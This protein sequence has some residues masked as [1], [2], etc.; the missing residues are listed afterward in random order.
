[1]ST[2]LE[3][4]STL[5]G[6]A[7]ALAE[8]L[9]DASGGT[10]ISLGVTSAAVGDIVKVKAVDENGKPTA[11]EAMTAKLAN[12][13][14][15][16]F[17]GAV[18]GSYDGSTPL[19]VE[20]PSGGGGS[21][22]S[23]SWKLIRTINIV[24]GTSSYSFDTDNNGNAFNVKNFLIL[25]DAYP[26]RGGH[27]EIKPNGNFSFYQT[28]TGKQNLP[29]SFMMKRLTDERYILEN[30]T[31]DNSIFERK[32]SKV[33]SS[34]GEFTSFVFWFSTNPAS[35]TTMYILGEDV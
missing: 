26:S 11:W 31:T 1:M 25:I 32:L 2:T 19:S 30:S 20:I 22:A 5:I 29:F 12:P 16:T 8:T 3:E 33:Y 17:T 15:L 27:L 14:A 9:P 24:S 21:G 23:E 18:S 35:D 10:D 7:Q 6:E 34:F 13:N 4:N 28:P